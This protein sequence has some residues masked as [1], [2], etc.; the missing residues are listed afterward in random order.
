MA[1]GTAVY[2]KTEEEDG[3]SAVSCQSLRGF[4]LRGVVVVC[5]GRAM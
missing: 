1:S 2:T 5:L 3:V 4:Q